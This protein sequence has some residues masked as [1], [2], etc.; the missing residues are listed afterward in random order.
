M[1]H[2]LLCIGSAHLDVIAQSHGD[3]HGVDQPG[4]VRIDVGGT[5]CNIAI[6]WAKMGANSCLLTALGPGPLSDLIS[7]HLI[8]EGVDLIVD[9]S[10]SMEIGA[11]CAHLDAQGEMK[12]AISSAPIERH[13]F[14]EDVL[15]DAFEDC[16][17][18]VADCNLSINA[19]SS[20][21]ME[22]IARA[23]PLYISAVSEEKALR[24][25]HIRGLPT[26]VSLNEREA[27]YL[28][29]NTQRRV[30]KDPL[31]LA[32]AVAFYMK[33]DCLMTMGE[34][35]AIHAAPDGAPLWSRPEELSGLGNR[36]GAGDG[37]LAAFV[38]ACSRGAPPRL[39]LPRAL[40]IAGLIAARDHTNLGAAQPLEDALSDLSERAYHDAIT[41]MSTQQG[42]R[43]GLDKRDFKSEGAMSVIVF[44]MSV[45]EEEPSMSELVECGALIEANMRAEDI[46]ARWSQ[47]E[48]VCFLPSTALAQAQEIAQR[49]TLAAN[50]GLSAG[51]AERESVSEPLDEL[52]TRAALNLSSKT[53]SIDHA[54]SEDEP[55]LE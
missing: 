48:F 33:C 42:A 38:L 4:S 13:E 14:D 12:Q 36:L 30:I 9:F 35:G 26:L 22:A 51:W 49:V 47:E 27:R 21:A 52:L 39:A 5:A 25:A 1:S 11:F 46:A 2:R 32:Q 28:I 7:S 29:S 53:L 55:G 34:R 20:I 40:R 18:A 10:P 45:D 17:M 50:G 54:P 6:N 31:D 41:G 44:R 8:R 24:M 37:F 16:A 19:L 23:V 43:E 3:P 15:E